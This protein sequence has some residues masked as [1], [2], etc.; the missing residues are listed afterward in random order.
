METETDVPF[1]KL[2]CKRRASCYSENDTSTS[3]G[4]TAKTEYA[5]WVS[6]YYTKEEEGSVWENL[7][8]CVE[9]ERQEETSRGP[10]TKEATKWEQ[11]EKGD[12]YD[13]RMD[14]VQWNKKSENWDPYEEC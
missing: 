4:I 5:D 11:S 10:A 9:K 1:T 8:C 13:R 3:W 2:L 7:P 14:A 12:A 6:S